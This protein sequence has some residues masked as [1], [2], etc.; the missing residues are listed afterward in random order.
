MVIIDSL[1]AATISCASTLITL[2]ADEY[3]DFHRHID[4][5]EGKV[6]AGDVVITHKNGDTY[7]FESGDKVGDY[8]AVEHSAL[9]GEKGV[10]IL[11]KNC[12]EEENEKSVVD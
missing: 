4:Y 11:L 1:L 9:A 7:Y 2:P 12:T 3:I 5:A 6:L 8:F 10:M